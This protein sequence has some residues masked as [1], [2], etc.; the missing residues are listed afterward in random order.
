MEAGTVS[1]PLTMAVEPGVA[2]VK[3]VE[4][5]N[6]L[7]ARRLQEA[8]IRFHGVVMHL[9]I[10]CGRAVYTEGLRHIGFDVKE[11]P[12][13]PVPAV[14][15]SMKAQ[16]CKAIDEARAAVVTTPLVAVSSSP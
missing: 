14:P 7:E 16:L 10:S 15:A 3:A 4:R 1:P 9:A 6:D 2:L 8:V 11:Y 13:W 12:R 5:G